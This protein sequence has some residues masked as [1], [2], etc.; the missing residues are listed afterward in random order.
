VL[1]VLDSTHGGVLVNGTTANARLSGDRLRALAGLPS[2]LLLYHVAGDIRNRY[3]ALDC[4][5]G[6]PGGEEFTW[7]DLNGSVRGSA[8]NFGQS[9][10]FRNGSTH[11]VFWTRGPIL[12]R[13]DNLRSQKTDLGLPVSDE[14]AISGG[15]R[16][17][18]ERGYITWNAS[19]GQTAFHKN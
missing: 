13:Y 14:F 10:L 11:K 15:R 16:S 2:T 3:D 4:A 7:R 12:S 8:Q 6:L 19:N 1:R 9:R 17:N 5:P 18:F